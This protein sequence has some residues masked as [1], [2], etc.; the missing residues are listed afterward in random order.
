MKL[1]PCIDIH[2]GSV[3]QIVGASL[4]KASGVRE[5]FV[6]SRDALYYAQLYDK[7]SLEGGHIIILNKRGTPEYEASVRTALPVLKECPGR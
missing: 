7:Y 6:S 1:R 5:N 4:E 2:D 3:K